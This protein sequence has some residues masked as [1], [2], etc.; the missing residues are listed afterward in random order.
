MASTVNLYCYIVLFP[1]FFISFKIENDLSG[2]TDVVG[3]VS[4]IQRAIVTFGKKLLI[5]F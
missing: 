3:I 4:V 2:E 5:F 1:I